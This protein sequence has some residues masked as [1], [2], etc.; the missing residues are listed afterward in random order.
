MILTSE[1]VPPP[2]P[3]MLSALNPN[4]ALI[5]TPQWLEFAVDKHPHQTRFGVTSQF[6]YMGL[7][8]AE[9]VN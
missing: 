4:P 1:V 5:L 7:K 3:T 9:F 2:P 8:H 6:T